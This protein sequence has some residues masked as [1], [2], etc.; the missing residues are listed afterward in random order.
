MTGEFNL[1]EFMVATG[2]SSDSGSDSTKY[3]KVVRAFP[4]KTSFPSLGSSMLDVEYEIWS[5]GQDQSIE[6]GTKLTLL[7]LTG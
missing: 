3:A 4:Y 2:S 7:C 5:K 6:E 1:S